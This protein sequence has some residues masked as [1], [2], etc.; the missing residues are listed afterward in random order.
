MLDFKNLRTAI[1][2]GGRGFACIRDPH[3]A[4][5]RQKAAQEFDL[6][7]GTLDRAVVR[8]QLDAIVHGGQ[9]GTDKAA[10]RWAAK[11]KFP[12]QEFDWNAHG[13]EAGPVR[14][15][16]MLNVARPRFV[17]AF[18]GGPGTKD[19]INRA[20]KVGVIVLRVGW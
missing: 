18:K 6:L 19:M 15:Q 9:R 16:T 11:R 3:S 13:K 14:N 8:L 2:C 10:G 1:V 5:Q 7:E 17:I 4:Q 12:C 20:M